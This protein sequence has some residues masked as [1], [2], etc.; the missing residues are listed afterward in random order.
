[1]LPC[2]CAQLVK[3][4]FSEAFPTHSSC[5]PVAVLSLTVLPQAMDVNL[6]PNKTSVLLHDM[7]R[8]VSHVAAYLRPPLTRTSS[9]LR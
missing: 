1:M 3:Q 9:S 8:G 4:A 2:C 7:V 6:E 5:H